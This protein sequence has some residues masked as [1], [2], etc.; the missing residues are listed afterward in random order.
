MARQKT[1][2]RGLTGAARQ[3]NH[4]LAAAVVVFT[5]GI[6]LQRLISPWMVSL[7]TWLAS[8]LGAATAATVFGPLIVDLPKA[9]LLLGVAF[10]LGRITMPRP[11]PTGVSVV[12]LVYLF[13]FGVH[14]VF[15]THVILFGH[16]RAIL[17]RGL[18]LALVIWAVVRLV[19]RGRQAAETADRQGSLPDKSSKSKK[20]TPERP[21]ED[22]TPDSTSTSPKSGNANDQT[23]KQHTSDSVR[24]GE[25]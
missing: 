22:R 25:R 10:P 19:D 5:A 21:P 20:K 2:W 3:A 13:D 4:V 24:E 8:A 7:S 9:L 16:W 12:T 23:C 14:Y 18:L 17:G 15:G 11:W 1:R 6:L